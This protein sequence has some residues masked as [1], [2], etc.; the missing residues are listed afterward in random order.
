[1]RYILFLACAIFL[2]FAAGCITQSPQSTSST[3]PLITATTIPI[4]IPPPLPTTDINTEKSPIE[5]NASICTNEKKFAT[6]RQS[7]TGTTWVLKAYMGKDGWMIPVTPNVRARCDYVTARFD[8]EGKLT[9]YSGCNGYSGPYTL[10][11][12]NGI[13]IGSFTT[14]LIYCYGPVGS[15]EGSYLKLLRNASS[16][17]TTTDGMLNLKDAAGTLILV[18]FA[19]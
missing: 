19:Q 17:E 18:Y 9:G 15:Q 14:T 1:M 4:T 3:L 7:F 2:I 11:G 5:K 16:Y 12:Q 6:T 8:S 13:Y 10:S